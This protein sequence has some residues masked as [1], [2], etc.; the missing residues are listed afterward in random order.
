MT[1]SGG[2]VSLVISCCDLGRF[3]TGCP[4]PVEVAVGKSNGDRNIMLMS[5]IS[6]YSIS[7]G[8]FVKGFGNNSEMN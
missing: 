3:V 5:L 6:R 1:L 2:N 4:E 8:K 7:K